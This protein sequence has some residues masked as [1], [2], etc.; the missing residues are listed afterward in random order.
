MK[1][2]ITRF[3]DWFEEKFNFIIDVTALIGGVFLILLAIITFIVLLITD[4]I[5][6]E[7]MEYIFIPG[8]IGFLGVM[9]L[10]ALRI[11]RALTKKSDKKEGV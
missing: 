2:K 6:F 5:L 1:N 10:F 7:N 3:I 9:I 11:T 4:T 8:F